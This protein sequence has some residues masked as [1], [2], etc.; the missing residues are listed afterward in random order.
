MSRALT[1]PFAALPVRTCQHCG[2]SMKL[3]E[4]HVVS[5]K[6]TQQIWWKCTECRRSRYFGA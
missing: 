6:Y 3:V 4:E 5:E 2:A 1:N